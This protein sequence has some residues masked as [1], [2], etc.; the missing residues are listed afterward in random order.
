MRQAPYICLFTG[1]KCFH[2]FINIKCLSYCHFLQFFF[3]QNS[4]FVFHFQSCPLEAF[5]RTKQSVLFHCL[6]INISLYLWHPDKHPTLNLSAT[7]Y[8]SPSQTH[9]LIHFFS[10]SLSLSLSISLKDLYYEI[11]LTVMFKLFVNRSV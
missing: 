8:I 1:T 3:L 4:Y 7:L 9:S 10:L 2:S 11:F 5:I 6:F